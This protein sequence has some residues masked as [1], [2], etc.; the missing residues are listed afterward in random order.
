MQ[1]RGRA[2]DLAKQIERDLPEFTVHDVSH[3][4][5]LWELADLIAGPKFTITPA[6]GFVIGA[7][8]LIHD[9]GLALAAYPEGIDEIEKTSL[10]A[11]LV[12]AILKERLG[13]APRPTEIEKPG[14]DIIE[15][16]KPRLLREL[17]AQH[18]ERLALVSWVDS[19]TGERLYLLDDSNLRADYGAV[20][21]K[22][23]HSHWWAVG[24]LQR[25]LS[26]ELGAPGSLPGEWTVNPLRIACV[27]RAADA[28]HL[29]ERRAPRFLRSLRRPTGLAAEHW[30]F[31]AKLN[32]PR[33]QADRLVYTASSPFE[34]H[35]APAWWIC[36]DSLRTVDGELRA[37][38]AL[39]ADLGMPRFAA[40]ALLGV[41]TPEQF[42]KYVPTRDWL[43]VDTKIR[44]SDVAGLVRSLGGE[45][46]YGR[47]QTVPLRELIQ[48][49]SDAVRA[50]RLVDSRSAS[51]GRII[52]RLGQ[53]D[54]GHWIEVEDTGV[55]MSP[56]V[57]TGSFLDFGRSGWESDVVLNEFPTLLS[58]GFE[59]TGKYGIGFFSVFMWGERARITTRRYDAALADTLQLDFTAD[60]SLRPILRNCPTTL[61]LRD[62]GTRVRI[63]FA[64]QPSSPTGL[65]AESTLEEICTRLA[66]S[67]AVD[68]VVETADGK[69]VRVISASDWRQI[70]APELI[71][72][73]KPVT[74]Q[75][76]SL[77]LSKMTERS[78]RELLKSLLETNLRE[79]ADDTG[80]I[81][82]RGCVVPWKEF[83]NDTGIVTVGG[84]VS[85]RLTGVGGIFL[86]S[87]LTASRQVAIPSVP[88]ETLAAWASEQASLLSC[89][90]ELTSEQK[91][92]CAATIRRCGGDTAD[93]P[94]AETETGWVSYRELGRMDNLPDEVYLLQDAAYYLLSNPYDAAPIAVRLHDNVFAVAVSW[95]AILQPGSRHPWVDWPPR[96]KDEVWREWSFAKHSLEGVL[97]EAVATVWKASIPAVLKASLH[98]TDK[99]TY[100]REIGLMPNGNSIR[101]N[102]DIL[103]NPATSR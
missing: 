7:A 52:V 9:L 30:A 2:A 64:E 20:I 11:D 8:F 99:T 5:A 34:A 35:E 53:D 73:I 60:L 101:K 42:V 82:A 97:I 3:L 25:H 40:N 48:N 67:L 51:W 74:H 81:V 33:L 92:D 76:R 84:L 61:G 31:Q 15:E 45:N 29:D 22:I 47:D 103:R 72:R 102:V 16:A 37:I 57:L 90:D 100:E 1:L 23:A 93:L 56:D 18:A 63:W 54:A 41:E 17:H 36:Y 24:E 71:R 10:W 69:Q 88:A 96:Q 13:R 75:L 27:L 32:Q 65:L 38:D 77:G 70:D 4:D 78:Q 68:L 85:C 89:C 28:A 55:G 43:P 83:Y 44:V 21:G 86:G 6:E 79:I 62:A 12:A 19:S 26:L 50:R 58:K 39:F 66:P 49:A 91:A 80:E 87:S 46:L 59:S 94:I 98:S 95:P 14:P